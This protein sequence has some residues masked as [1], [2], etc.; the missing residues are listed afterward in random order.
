MA[1]LPCPHKNFAASIA[2]NRIGETE[3]GPADGYVAD[4][5]VRCTDC[6]Q[7]FHWIGAPAGLDPDKPCVSADKTELR[8]PL[9]VGPIA[10]RHRSARTYRAGSIEVQ[11][12]RWAGG[13]ESARPIVNW[14]R[15]EGARARY[16]GD[17]ER[18]EVDTSGGT[19]RMRQGWWL[20][21]E[22]GEFRPCE[23]DIFTAIYEA[24]TAVKPD[25]E[26]EWGFRRATDP[27]FYVRQCA[28]EAARSVVA[29]PEGEDWVLVS[30]RKA[31]PWI[32]VTS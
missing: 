27:E 11:A 6:H 16:V 17:P 29:D 25:S 2:V 9:H 32:E 1:D 4:I 5:T 18:L 14:A 28:E 7:P 13:P 19:M 3:D 20:I 12:M 21:Q 22:A 30:R 23:P 15:S 24:V 26:T 31:G 10:A 8:A